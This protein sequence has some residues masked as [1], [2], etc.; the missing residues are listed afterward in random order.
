MIHLGA[1]HINIRPKDP[2]PQKISFPTRRMA[3]VHHQISR[4][5]ITRADRGSH[6]NN[7]DSRSITISRERK[8]QHLRPILI[9]SQVHSH[10]PDAIVA[11]VA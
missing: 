11:K 1:S 9:R 4:D 2:G 3:R 7:R 10:S 5:N 6:T 8:R